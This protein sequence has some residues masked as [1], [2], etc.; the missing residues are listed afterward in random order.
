MWEAHQP[1]TPEPGATAT[2]TRTP[3]HDVVL[4]FS[5]DS[6]ADAV[7]RGFCRPPEQLAL[8]LRADERIG[9]LLVADAFRSRAA[10]AADVVR[11]R[12]TVVPDDRRI[13][14]VKPRQWARRLPNTEQEARAMAARYDGALARAARGA[15]L[16]APVVITSNALVAA[17]ADLN[18]AARVVFYARDDWAAKANAPAVR[19]AFEVAYAQLRERR[20]SVAAVSQ[21]ILDRLA[22]TGPSLV[23]PNGIDPDVWAPARPEP[24]DLADLPRPIVAYA[25]TIND[26]LD[27]DAVEQ[28][29]TAVSGGTVLLAGPLGHSHPL[30]RLSR[31]PAVR[32]AGVLP[33]AQLA[34]VL[35]H[36]DA[37]VMPHR[38]TA[39]TEAMCPLKLVNYLA[40]GQPVVTTDLPTTRGYGD[41]VIGVPPGGD[42]AAALR[43]A[44]AKGRADESARVS[45]VAANSWRGRHRALIDLALGTTG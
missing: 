38:R 6:W 27:A 21:V 4:T 13:Q 17:F 9:H 30:E 35:Q 7:Q 43:L 19:H 16:A 23:V 25:G 28:I 44:L 42:W 14:L 39:L 5:T 32:Y 40:A 1:L 41:R 37:C 34:A 8:S 24:D 26:R 11:G 15:G 22:P 29:A 33:Q 2:A 12:T 45:F 18:W 10:Q 31:L 3:L 36:V 20:R